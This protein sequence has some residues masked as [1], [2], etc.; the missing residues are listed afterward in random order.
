MPANLLKTHQRLDGL[1]DKLYGFKTAPTEAERV[2]KLFTLYEQLCT[3]LL[4]VA[5]KKGR[6]RAGTV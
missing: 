1:V 3:P 6:K 2:A 5:Q 4:P